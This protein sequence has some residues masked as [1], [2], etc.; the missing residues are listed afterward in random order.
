MTSMVLSVAE[1]E[2]AAMNLKC[3]SARAAGGEE[4]PRS[5]EPVLGDLGQGQVQHDHDGQSE[6]ETTGQ[7]WEAEGMGDGG[8][9]EQYRQ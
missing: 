7:R 3:G 8:G 5:E 9:R 1:T 2:R 6:E 4:G